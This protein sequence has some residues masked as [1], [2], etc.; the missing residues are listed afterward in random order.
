MTRSSDE[1]LREFAVI[2]AHR[3]RLRRERA[4]LFCE[5]AEAVLVDPHTFE[6]LPREQDEPC[7]KAARRWDD[8]QSRARFYFDPPTSQWCASCQRRQIVSDAY[9]EAVKRHAGAL[10]GLLAR[11]KGQLLTLGAAHLVDAVARTDEKVTGGP[12]A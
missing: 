12:R 8:S 5:R 7:W 9:R 6:S 10:R 3:D 1:L 11:G 2:R 4:A